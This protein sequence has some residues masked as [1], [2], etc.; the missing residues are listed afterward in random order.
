[1]TDDRGDGVT[2]DLSPDPFEGVFPSGLVNFAPELEVFALDFHAG[3]EDLDALFGQES[4]V[5]LSGAVDALDETHA[6]TPGFGG[7]GLSR[8]HAR[9]RVLGS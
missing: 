2:S 5:S 6:A 4:F 9:Y 7:R 3:G 8:S 1:M